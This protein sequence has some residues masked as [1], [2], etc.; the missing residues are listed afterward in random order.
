[1]DDKGIYYDP[2]R[3]SRLE[4]LLENSHQLQNAELTRA[5]SVRRKYVSLNLSKYN[6]EGVKHDIIP[7]DGQQIVLVPGQVEDD[8]SIMLGA[9]NVRTNEAL[10]KAVRKLLPEAYIIYKPHPDVEAGL[11]PG[12]VSDVVLEQVD[13]IADRG[14]ITQL[15]DSADCVATMTSLV[16][17]EALLRDK[18]V[19]C[20]GAPF[21]AGWG[22]TD[23]MV[24]TPKRRKTR[25]SLDQ[26]THAALIDYPLY[27]DP[28]TQDPCTIEG[29]LSR[30]EKGQFGSKGG[31]STRILSKIQGLF[32]SFSSVWR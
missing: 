24:E 20:Y 4:T 12:H 29:V 25:L 1:V 9:K 28:V 3:P 27:W 14:N 19:I 2:S 8:A 22:L 6:I 31:A 11:R 13:Y 15:I 30:F 23:D 32:A 16:G 21:Y 18:T 10:I 5:H 7:K 17:F 26:L